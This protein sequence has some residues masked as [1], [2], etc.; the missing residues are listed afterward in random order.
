M[1]GTK[2]PNTA[3]KPPVIA[4]K[5]LKMPPITDPEWV[6]QNDKA[7]QGAQEVVTGEEEVVTGEEERMVAVP[8]TMVL[9]IL[10]V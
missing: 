10:D 5:K 8:V 3:I 2:T 1:Q 7:G 6:S 9:Y 4:P